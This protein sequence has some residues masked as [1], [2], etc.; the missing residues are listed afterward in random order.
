VSGS[1]FTGNTANDSGGAI[2][3]YYSTL[4]VSGSTFTGN[5]ANNEGGAI[6]NMGT[7]DAHFNRFVGNTATQGSAI[8]CSSGDGVNAEV[9]AENNWWGSNLDPQTV[10]NLIMMN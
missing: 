2:Y 8:Y 3:N 7:S 5:T 10:P 6:Y 4:N 9:D 1:T